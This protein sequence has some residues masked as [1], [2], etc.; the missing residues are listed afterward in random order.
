VSDFYL[1]TPDLQADCLAQLA[2]A[3]LPHWGLEAE[4]L[5]LVKYRENA[6]FKISL[7]ERNYALRIHRP[8]YHS[9]AALRSELEWMA[10]LGQAGIAVPEVIPSQTGELLVSATVA[11]VP[12]PRY[13]DLFAWIDGQPLGSVEQGVAYSE[14]QID[15]LYRQIGQ[16]AAQLH[17]HSSHWSAPQGFERHAWDSAGLL[18]DGLEG[19]APFWGR[20][21]QLEA[22]SESQRQLLLKAREQVAEQLAQLDKSPQRY[23]LIHADF[24]PE[25]LMTD[26]SSVRLIDFD[27]AGFGWHLFELA[28]AL[29]FIRTQACYPQAKQA[30]IEGYREFRALP[31]SELNYLEALLTARGFSYLGWI[32]DRQETE[33]AQQ[34]SSDLITRAC[35]QA[36]LF[37]DS[38]NQPFG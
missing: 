9:Q 32:R 14:S 8:G 13:V 24:V 26:G 20:F 17:N 28:T 25:N 36:Q 38:K 27:D 21:W 2:L 5:S 6:V 22:L 15:S 31:D 33:T 12:E 19:Q 34:L 10:A 35:T 29:Y 16:L 3:A 30:L 11:S 23:G 1:L 37:L 4:S 18:G 7:G